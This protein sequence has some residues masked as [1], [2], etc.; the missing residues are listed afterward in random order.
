MS[1][2]DELC[3]VDLETTGLSLTEDRIV[4]YCF[5]NYTSA[6]QAEDSHS[7]HY[8]DAHD[9]FIDPEGVPISSGAFRINGIRQEDLLG[10]PKF[11]EQ[12]DA[13]TNFV[14]D[15]I[16]VAHNATFDIGMLTSEFRRA[17]KEFNYH[18]I[19]TL[20]VFKN[21]F[22]SLDS[23]TL[24]YLCSRCRVERNGHNA[25]D[26]AVA[27]YTLFVNSRLH[28][29][30]DFQKEREVALLKKQGRMFCSKDLKM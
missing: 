11:H 10:K 7:T 12:I 16:L 27:L 30:I 13:I 5:L 19:D 26:D 18:A 15:R 23:Y 9:T 4:S 22:P 3:F 8:I 29:Y 21:S 1:I 6:G 20:Q 2:L 24:D 17:Q 28:E 14:G 25:V